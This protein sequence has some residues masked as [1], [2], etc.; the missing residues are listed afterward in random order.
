MTP[1]ARG[2]VELVTAA[3]HNACAT[4]LLQLRAEDLINLLN[5]FEAERDQRVKSGWPS[6]KRQVP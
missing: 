6:A 5:P 3:T 4:G 1:P 2:G